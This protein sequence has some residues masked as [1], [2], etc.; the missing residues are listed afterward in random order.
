MS[1]SLFE[2]VVLANGEV[3]LQRANDEREPLIRIAFSAEVQDFLEEAKIDVAKVM[4]DAGIELFEQLGSDLL[5][6]E[7]GETLDISPRVVH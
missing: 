3:A 7:E 1:V 5:Q 2:I 4:I 6:I